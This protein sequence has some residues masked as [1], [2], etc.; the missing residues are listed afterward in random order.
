MT[1]KNSLLTASISVISAVSGYALAPNANIQ[2]DGQ[3][4]IADTT[5]TAYQD[6]VNEQSAI[7]GFT[8]GATNFKPVVNGTEAL[9]ELYIDTG[10][11]AIIIKGGNEIIPLFIPAQPKVGSGFIL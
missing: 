11:P 6:L 9:M 5:N 7:F 8:K 3:Y 1:I 2:F 10:N 4:A